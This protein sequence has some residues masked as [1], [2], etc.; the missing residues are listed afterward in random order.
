LESSVNYLSDLS[1]K[2]K[3]LQQKQKTLKNRQEQPIINLDLPMEL[4]ET[5]I[6]SYSNLVNDVPF[7]C[8]KNG[9][10]P[11]FRQ[12]NTTV[13][14]KS[15]YALQPPLPQHQS[16]Y[17]PPPQPQ[18]QPSPPPS[19]PLQQ[20]H[21]PYYT[22]PP[23]PQPK[24]FPLQHQQHQPLQQQQPYYAP[25]PEPLP[26]PHLYLS[27]EPFS[28]RGEERGEEGEKENEKKKE[29][30]EEKRRENI[31]LGLKSGTMVKK[32]TIIKKYTLGK[33][34][35]NKTISIL[36][37]N[38]KTRRTIMDA[39]KDLKKK[40]IGEI[41]EYLKK[42][43]LIKVG[44]TAPNDVIR[45]TYESVMLTGDVTNTDKDLLIHNLLNDK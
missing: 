20:H 44:S 19:F 22:P 42:H 18:P 16:Y 9:T 41:K 30:E 26:I 6:P 34:K 24:P 12:W 37:K 3:L 39:H 25:P 14:N 17:A 2:Y 45:K 4:K 15:T 7:G 35:I 40:S 32:R 33:S 43:G 8:L 23:L 38:N 29:K 27:Q 13:K 31:E 36:L 1:H 5:N 11:T 21:Q 10:K 28:E